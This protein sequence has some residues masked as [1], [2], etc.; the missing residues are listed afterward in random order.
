MIL[1]DTN[2]VSETMRAT[3]E[4]KVIEWVDSQAIET[5]YLSAIS[6]AELLLG[7]AA[8][9]EGR[10]KVGLTRSLNEQTALLFKERILAFDNAAA[11]AYA[12]V[13]T[14]STRR[15]RPIGLADAQIAAI[16]TVY[17]LAVATRDV[18]PFEAAGLRVINP[19]TAAT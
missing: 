15:G 4:R 9:P 2:V 10:R 14:S 13:V 6:L 11:H 5:L 16:A 7:V 17:R 3:P 19:W 12:E 18:G 1:V 8:L